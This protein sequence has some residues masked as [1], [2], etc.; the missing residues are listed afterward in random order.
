MKYFA[1]YEE[2]KGFFDTLH[3]LSTVYWHYA[4]ISNHTECD[5]TDRQR[6]TAKRN[7]VKYKYD[8]MINQFSDEQLKYFKDELR[9]VKI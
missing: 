5:R 9:K 1:N 8:E 4:Y 6:F 7:Y 2:R 3:K